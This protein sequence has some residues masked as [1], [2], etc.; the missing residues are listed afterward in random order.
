MGLNYINNAIDELISLLG[1]KE[2]V[3]MDEVDP[4]GWTGITLS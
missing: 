2:D 3:P 4:I 1:I